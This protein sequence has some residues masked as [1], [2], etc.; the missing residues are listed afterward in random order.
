MSSPEMGTEINDDRVTALLAVPPLRLDEDRALARLRA[1]TVPN[2]RPL[3]RLRAVQAFAAAAAVVLVASALTLDLHR[4]V[5][6]QAVLHP[7]DDLRDGRLGNPQAGRDLMLRATFEDLLHHAEF[8]KPHA[9]AWFTPTLAAARASLAAHRRPRLER[10]FVGAIN[11]L[12][13][14]PVSCC[15]RSRT[16]CT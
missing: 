14:F 12:A 1:A 13:F 7:P 15:Q 11:C 8:A 4:D 2:P 9:R 5:S 16:T 3:L 10:A 6:Q